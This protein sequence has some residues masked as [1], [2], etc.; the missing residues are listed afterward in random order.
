M[1]RPRCLYAVHAATAVTA[2]I[3]LVA[4]PCRGDSSSTVL[5]AQPGDDLQA[6]VDAVC[7]LGGGTVELQA[8]TYYLERTLLLSCDDLTLRGAGMDE[9]FVVWNGVNDPNDT[10]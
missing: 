9:T 10:L 3:L 5:V 6:K 1:P 8:E 4:S 7:A 2:S